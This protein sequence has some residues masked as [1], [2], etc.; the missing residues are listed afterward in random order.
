M[1]TFEVPSLH[2]FAELEPDLPRGL[3]YPRDRL[4]V[5]RGRA[6]APARAGGA[7]ALR[8][9]LPYRIAAR[10]SQAHATVAS[11]HYGVVSRAVVDRCH[12]IGVPVIAWTVDSPS[13]LA[14][15]EAAGVDAVVSND[16]RIFGATLS[17]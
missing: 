17:A 9:V 8:A 6:L 3:S 5:S 1:T 7:A 11:L 14:R 4:G 13:L 12:A 16:P 15:L 10:L 2:R